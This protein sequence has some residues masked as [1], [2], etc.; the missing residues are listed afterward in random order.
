MDGNEPATIDRLQAAV[1]SVKPS[2]QSIASAQNRRRPAIDGCLGEPQPVAIDR[3][4]ST[5]K[6][7][8]RR[9]SSSARGFDAA[10]KSTIPSRVQCCVP[11]SVRRQSV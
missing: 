6:F 1:D 4:S 7:R 10:A 3:L 5:L 9:G 2:L 8:A 11:R